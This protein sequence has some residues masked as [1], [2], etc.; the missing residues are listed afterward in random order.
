MVKALLCE[1][2][3]EY[4]DDNNSII[5][6]FNEN[7]ILTVEFDNNGQLKNISGNLSL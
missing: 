3:I 6:K 7:S 2:E 5:A 4:S 1:N